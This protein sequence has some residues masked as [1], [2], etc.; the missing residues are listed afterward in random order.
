MDFI[1]YSARPHGTNAFP[2]VAASPS[3]PATLY[4]AEYDLVFF[5][6]GSGWTLTAQ[7]GSNSVYS[8]FTTLDT[9]T[10]AAISASISNTSSAPHAAHKS[11]AAKT[12][13]LVHGK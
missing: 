10:K 12:T 1:N 7:P 11:V 8:T 2:T 4:D 9:N 5:N 6:T 3:S 13:D